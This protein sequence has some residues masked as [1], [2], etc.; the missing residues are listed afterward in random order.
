VTLL[1]SRIAPWSA[2]FIALLTLSAVPMRLTAELRKQ[3]GAF[4]YATNAV[5]QTMDVSPDGKV[6]VVLMNEPQKG[7]PA[8]I[9]TFDPS[10]GKPLDEKIFGSGPLAV[11]MTSGASGSRVVA[12]T[13]EGGPRT[14]R[15]FDVSPAGRLTEAA[16]RTLT[17]AKSDSGSNL[18]LDGEGQTGFAVVSPGPGQP[19]R[20]LVAFSLVDGF[21]LSR[22]AI[23]NERTNEGYPRNV[24]ALTKTDGRKLIVFLRDFRALGAIDVS[25]PTNPVTMRDMELPSKGPFSAS[26]S[27]FAF[28]R[29]GRY[30]F[31]SQAGAALVTVDL[32]AQQA[33]GATPGTM[34]Y[35]HVALYEDGRKRLG[36]VLA[37]RHDSGA[38]VLL[39]FDLTAPAQPEILRSMR[40]PASHKAKLSFTGDGQR[41]FVLTDRKLQLLDVADLHEIWLKDAGENATLPQGLVVFG[42]RLDRALAAW[43]GANAYVDYFRADQE[44]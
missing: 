8:K 23:P 43:G 19:R 42:P 3:N 17:S 40:L 29:D 2:C 22:T 44:P 25:R 13:S 11:Q 27:G 21:V 5:A 20:Q 4:L 18:V 16:S 34:M 12:L 14:V 26:A 31:V 30:A 33:I 6:A 35:N 24:I 41:L 32:K 15:F 1:I 7:H 9:V 10:T 37:E 38:G 28:S 39:L 36:A